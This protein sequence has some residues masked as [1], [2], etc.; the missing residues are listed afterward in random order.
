MPATHQEERKDSQSHGHCNLPEN[1]RD[2]SFWQ[3]F[4]GNAEQWR[5]HAMNWA[6]QVRNCMS[7]SAP[8]VKL[9]VVNKPSYVIKGNPNETI[10]VPIEFRNA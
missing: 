2:N 4:Q 9:Y 3:Q 8:E 5:D 10:I 6:D 7:P 1:L